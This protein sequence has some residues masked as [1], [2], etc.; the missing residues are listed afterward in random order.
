MTALQSS[1]VQI[2]TAQ[3]ADWRWRLNNLYWIVDK[4]GKRVLF[5]ENAA[6]IKFLD[7]MWYLN[8]VLKS[9]Q[10]GF[11]TVIQLIMLDACMFNPDIACGTI[12]HT[13]EDAEVIFATK[14]KFPYDN[15]PEGLRHENPA[16]QDSAR[17]LSFRNNSSLGV[18]TS[19]RSQTLQ[20]LHVSEFGK[21]CARYPEKAKEVKTGAFNT[22]APGQMMFVESTAEG[23]EGDFAELCKESRANHGRKLSKLQFRF[24]FAPWWEDP[25]C[26]LPPHSVPVS[27]TTQERLDKLAEQ[28]ISLEADQIA[29]YAAKH[30]VMRGDM[31]R[32]Y[33]STPEE[34][35]EAGEPGD[36]YDIADFRWYETRP[37]A[38]R[39][40]GASDY[41]ITEDDGDWSV[42]GVCGVDPNDDIYIVDWW[43]ERVNS[44]DSVEAAIDM[45]QKHD[46]VAWAEEKA[47]IEKALGPFIKKRMAERRVY[48]FRTQLPSH[49]DKQMKGRSFQAR[50]QQG[51]VYL[52][53][54]APWVPA[55]TRELDMY[56]GPSEV[57]DDQHDVCGL[58]GRILDKM[59]KA[60]KP[61]A[62]RGDHGL[63]LDEAIAQDEEYNR[64]ANR[65]MAGL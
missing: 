5:H 31:Y 18:G 23:D 26:T 16:V 47:Q 3:F 63:T 64:G 46:T 65:R 62:P 58:F 9:R 19:M 30:A 44:F 1:D 14:A 39:L 57:N 59:S 8:C 17:H 40:Y 7:E 32:E 25:D 2:L 41:A 37:A 12:A 4:A 34:A 33:P 48:K 42:H 29:W 27:A 38:L 13:R 56:G 45:M 35:F 15:L 24:H 36:Y 20:Y 51:K 10:R 28:G 53:I 11:S 49:Q 21:I 55:L 60:Q 54:G 43:R 52:P 22:V 6:Q 50:Q 61:E